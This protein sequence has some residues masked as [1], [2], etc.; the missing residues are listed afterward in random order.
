MRIFGE[1]SFLED[2]RYVS[3][4]KNAQGKNS[5]TVA[6]V[7]SSELGKSGTEHRSRAAATRA[8]QRPRLLRRA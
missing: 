6:R 7:N 5:H 1:Y 8:S 4:A 2:S 3:Q